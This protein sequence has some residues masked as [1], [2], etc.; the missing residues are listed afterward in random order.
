MASED[1]RAD[2]E[3]LPFDAELE[4][5]PSW[6]TASAA[7]VIVI[8]GL[9]AV[10]IAPMFAL[11]PFLIASSLGRRFSS[12]AVRVVIEPGRLLIGRRT[13]NLEEIAHV[14]HDEREARVMIARPRSSTR[15]VL[16]LEILQLDT[17]SQGTR[18]VRELEAR[19][20][21][22]ASP[23]VLAVAGVAPRPIDALGSLRFLALAL[24][25]FSTGSWLGVAI[26]P[27]FGLYGLSLLSS[28]QLIATDRE[29]KIVAPL[30][31]TE[32][33][34]RAGIRRIVRDRGDYGVELLDGRELLFKPRS[35][36]DALMG[37]TSWTE[38]AL[39]H[40]LA[41][42]ETTDEKEGETTGASP[43]H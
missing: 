15:D 30:T 10:H 27:L 31:A 36:R 2:D 29:L 4:G 22:H 16:D 19:R 28:R 17:E 8:A 6:V 14:W 1:H 37:S 32:R 12:T 24:V 41:A 18:F 13:I 33:H 34:D 40:V 43:S 5:A 20:P 25:F 7:L 11:L 3:A 42:L 9:V 21:V 23:R 35:I 26:L 39:D 38:R